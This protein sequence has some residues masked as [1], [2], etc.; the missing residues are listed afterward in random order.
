MCCSQEVPRV[1]GNPLTYLC[2]TSQ[3]LPMQPAVLGYATPQLIILQCYQWESLAINSWCRSTHTFHSEIVLPV[4]WMTSTNA[5]NKL[6]FQ[7]D[8]SALTQCY[9]DGNSVHLIFS[10]IALL[11]KRHFSLFSCHL[12]ILPFSF[13]VCFLF[14]DLALFSLSFNGTRLLF[15]KA[16]ISNALQTERRVQCLLVWFQGFD[17]EKGFCCFITFEKGPK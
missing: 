14:L 6:L 2:I 12:C 9:S 4:E 7:C 13:C 5:Q 11:C 17:E 8:H 15:M 16:Q 1:S 10:L 3:K